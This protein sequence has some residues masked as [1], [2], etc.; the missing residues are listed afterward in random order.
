MR[1]RG[2]FVGLRY[3]IVQGRLNSAICARTWTM[4]GRCLRYCGKSSDHAAPLPAK[5]WDERVARDGHLA[6]RLLLIEA[7]QQ[8]IRFAPGPDR[9]PAAK[10][11]S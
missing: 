9:G 2:R 4:E 1:H 11:W 6:A 10:S 8:Q 7:R 3:L 5:L